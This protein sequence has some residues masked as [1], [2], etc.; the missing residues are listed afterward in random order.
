ME[1]TESITVHGRAL[2]TEK[3]VGVILHPAEHGI[4]FTIKGATFHSSSRS[5]VSKELCSMMMFDIKRH[6]LTYEHLLAALNQLH[7]PNIRIELLDGATEL[8]IL[9]GSAQGWVDLLKYNIKSM[10]QTKF[11]Q[12]KLIKPVTV[13]DGDAYIIALPS[14]EP[15]YSYEQ[16]FDLH[17]TQSMTR[18]KMFNLSRGDWFDIMA[19]PTITVEGMGNEHKYNTGF[20]NYIS[21]ESTSC[22]RD[23]LVNHKLLDLIGDTYAN[24]MR[25]IADIEAYKTGH[26]HNNMLMRKILSD[27]TNYIIV[28]KEV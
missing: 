13:R 4:S 22:H 16:N 27:E 28:Q 11:N 5:T 10:G 26:S 23:S 3:A 7:I 24:G 15:V 19:E 6:V 20:S 21:D 17:A 18:M 2:H 14:R 25:L 8:P 9:D 12:I 1:L